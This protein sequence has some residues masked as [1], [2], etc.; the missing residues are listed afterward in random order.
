MQNDMMDNNEEKKN[1]NEEK[2]FTKPVRDGK[3]EYIEREVDK[4][5]FEGYEV[6][7]REFFSKGN[8]PAITIKYDAI[9]FNL[10]AIRKIG[11]SSHFIQILMNINKQSMIAK[12][13]D[14]DDKDSQQWSRITKN[15]KLVPRAIKGKVFC[16]KLY[17][18]MNWD[19]RSTYKILGMLTKCGEERLF[20]FNL[21]NAEQY[22]RLAAPT[23]DDPNR[24]ERIPFMP[25]HWLET[26]GQSYEESKKPVIETFVGVPDGYVQITIPKLPPKKPVDDKTTEAPDAQKPDIE[27]TDKETTEDGNK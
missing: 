7:M 26:Y 27:P 19:E 9:S 10:R 24:Y 6:V 2:K 4:F 12:P 23:A 13:C 20:E 18:D 25:S 11:E 16:A 22:L 3:V 15:G 5:D 8:I 14:E 1:K 17:K 21:T